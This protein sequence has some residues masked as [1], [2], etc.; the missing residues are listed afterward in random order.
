[1]DDRSLSSSAQPWQPSVAAI[2]I[3]LTGMDASIISMSSGSNNTGVGSGTGGGSRRLLTV[4]AVRARTARRTE[5]A[6]QVIAAS[7]AALAATDA[8]LAASDALLAAPRYNNSSSSSSVVVPA[9]TNDKLSSG[10]DDECENIDNEATAPAPITPEACEASSSGSDSESSD[11][12]LSSSSS[13]SSAVDDDDDIMAEKFRQQAQPQPPSSASSL[14]AASKALSFTSPSG[15]EE[16]SSS[17]ITSIEEGKSSRALSVDV[18]FKQRGDSPHGLVGLAISGS[19]LAGS[20]D[21][22]VT[23]PKFIMSLA[24]GGA[25]P[26]RSSASQPKEDIKAAALEH[27]KDDEDQDSESDSSS[28]ISSSSNYSGD[29]SS[30]GSETEQTPS[31]TPSSDVEADAYVDELL[32]EFTGESTT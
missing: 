16:S 23:V 24:T 8:L 2:P 11:N 10:Y 28:G 21:E 18:M 15:M 9:T 13:S 7:Q 6:M 1:M 25:A 17:H 12:Q 32:G 3:S 31:A 14:E 30:G 27:E 22:K 5:F 29:S 4:A 20:F 19:L 26:Q